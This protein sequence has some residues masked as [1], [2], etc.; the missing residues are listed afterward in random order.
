MLLAKIA[1]IILIFALLF[2][3]QFGFIHYQ[4]AGMEPV[5]KDGDIV[6]FYRYNSSGF[7]A[8][9]V[10]VV[11]FNGKKQVS[12]VVATAGDTVDIVGDDLIINGALQQEADIFKPTHSYSEGIE[13][14]I[15]VPEGYVFV[16][17]D[18]RTNSTDSRIYGCVKI[19]DSLGKVML[20]IKRRGI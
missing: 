10:V 3:F 6:I 16:L 4:D 12:R 14:P 1:S 2:T 13:F 9:D 8:Q 17:G 11:K 7:Q 5:I 15:T 19:S 20:V 18:N